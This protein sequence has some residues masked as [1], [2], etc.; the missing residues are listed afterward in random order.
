MSTDLSSLKDH[1]NST[2][3]NIF[4]WIKSNERTSAEKVYFY[5]NKDKTVWALEGV[6]GSFKDGDLLGYHFKIP[7]EEGDITKTYKLTS[8]FGAYHSIDYPSHATRA[9]RAEEAE[10][11][12]TINTFTERATGSFKATFREQSAHMNVTGDF[13]MYYI[14]K[15]YL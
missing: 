15:E 1:E 12:I 14:Q 5:H 11:T 7:Y 4:T 3:K 8:E 2:P 13:E 10:V 9:Y 6:T